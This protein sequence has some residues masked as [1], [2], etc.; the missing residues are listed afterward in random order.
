[1]F[2][3]SDLEN[4]IS[5]V[6]TNNVATTIIPKEK[7]T[8]YF[9]YYFARGILKFILKDKVNHDKPSKNGCLFDFMQQKKDILKSMRSNAI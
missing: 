3:D 9:L 8:S 5:I 4:G 2:A 7:M 1:L 6:T